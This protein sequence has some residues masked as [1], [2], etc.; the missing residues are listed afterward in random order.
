MKLR[1]KKETERKRG[2][3]RKGEER[4]EEKRL[5]ADSFSMLEQ[6]PAPA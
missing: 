4:K 5:Q 1:I 2:E 6:D 3:E